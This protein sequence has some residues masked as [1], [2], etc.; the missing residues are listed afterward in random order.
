MRILCQHLGALVPEFE[1]KLAEPAMIPCLLDEA[2]CV[3]QSND[4]GDVEDSVVKGAMDL[5]LGNV[6]TS[7]G[8][9]QVVVSVR[10]QAMKQFNN[11]LPHFMVSAL[12]AMEASALKNRQDICRELRSVSDKLRGDSSIACARQIFNDL[13]SRCMESLIGRLGSRE[14]MFRDQFLASKLLR[15]QHEKEMRPSLANPQCAHLLADLKSRESQR[16]EAFLADIAAVHA[17]FKNIFVEEANFFLGSAHAS[18]EAHFS[19]M[20]T[21]PLW[22]HFELVPGDEQLKKNYIFEY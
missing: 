22:P 4:D 8:F 20:D 11:Q 6:V 17:D 3:R 12:A 19:V 1:S 13:D 18:M 7:S 15:T 9:Q 10:D 14:K 21:I 16:H 5:I 2:S